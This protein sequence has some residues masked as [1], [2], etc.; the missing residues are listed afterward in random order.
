[1]HCERHC[2]V[3]QE[4]CNGTPVK[5]TTRSYHCEHSNVADVVTAA[6]RG[7]HQARAARARPAAPP[8]GSGGGASYRSSSAGGAA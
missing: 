1:M 2:S 4:R 7:A 5:V 6:V 3:C 8:G